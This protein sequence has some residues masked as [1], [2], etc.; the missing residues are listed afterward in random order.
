M[1]T[2]NRAGSGEE[3]SQSCATAGHRSAANGLQHPSAHGA[4]GNEIC[5]GTCTLQ[6]L[7]SA[8][9]LALFAG[10]VGNAFKA[11]KPAHTGQIQHNPC[12]REMSASP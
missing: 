5:Q 9:D 12:P 6:T 7:L 10:S 2:N 3:N 4:K 11:S 1:D 8:P